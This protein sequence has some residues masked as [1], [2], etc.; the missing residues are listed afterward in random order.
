[1]SMAIPLLLPHSHRDDDSG[2]FFSK[3][4]RRRRRFINTIAAAYF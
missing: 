1:M 3:P 2:I 4:S